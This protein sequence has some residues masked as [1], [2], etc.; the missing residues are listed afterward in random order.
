MP[1]RLPALRSPRR[2]SV[3][4]IVMI[5]LLFATFALLAFM[6]KASVDLLVDQR[7]IVT[8]RLRTE[9]YSALE[10]TLGVLNEFREAGN[11][12]RST[13]EGWGDP[14]GFAGYAPTDGRVVAIAFEDESGK[15]SLPHAPAQVLVALFKNWE[16]SQSGAE[17]LADALLGWMKHGHVYT[18]AIQPS[19]DSG[20]LPFEAPGRPVRA[21]G[22]LLAIEKVRETFFDADGRPNDLWKRLVDVV[23][24]LDFPK[25]NLNNAKPD[26]LAALGQFDAT[27][28]R[29][30]GEY[31]QGTGAYERQG[32]QFFQNPADAQRIAGPTGDAGAFGATIS[33]LRINVT[34]QDGRNEL[35]VS[36]VVAPPGG[37][38]TVNTK[39]THTQ[40]TGAAAQAVSQ[41]QNRPASKPAQPAAASLKYPFTLLEIREND[42][43]PPPPPPRPNPLF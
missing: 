43:I 27:Q 28:Q 36:C 37:A 34:V 29:N 3:L 40:T 5:T 1:A 41:A 26:A 6:E 20:L 16:L 24:L 33:A 35:R 32:P 8:R 18:S 12:L 39:A 42:E 14:L 4:I 22:E 30:L 17:N 9:A 2:G 21:W 19:Y 31:L 10:V 11:G 38:T 7:D 15:I 23:S 25:T 13:A